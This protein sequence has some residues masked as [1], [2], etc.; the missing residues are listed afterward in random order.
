MASRKTEPRNWPDIQSWGSLW[1]GCQSQPTFCWQSVME[2]VNFQAPLSCAKTLWG[3]LLQSKLHLREVSCRGLR[4]I[5]TSSLITNLNVNEAGLVIQ[6]SGRCAHLSH[7]ECLGL[8]VGHLW[9]SETHLYLS[10]TAI[11]PRPPFPRIYWQDHLRGDAYVISSA[12]PAPLLLP[13]N[14]LTAW[15]EF[16]TISLIPPPLLEAATTA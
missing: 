2:L 15:L 16:R 5:F 13:G 9:S 3:G 1:H 7:R 4:E 6:L 11:L 10:H 14:S 12:G 8:M